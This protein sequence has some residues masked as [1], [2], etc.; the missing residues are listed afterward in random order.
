MLHI[1]ESQARPIDLE[2]LGDSNVYD[3]A[4]VA[5][6]Y[7]LPGGV[8]AA[9]TDARPGTEAQ[10]RDT[11]HDV[12]WSAGEARI[13]PRS[14]DLSASLDQLPAPDES[15][16]EDI[17]RLQARSVVPDEMQTVYASKRE[18]SDVPPR[19]T[20]TCELRAWQLAENSQSMDSRALEGVR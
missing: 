16:A 18:K 5:G 14:M 13:P 7:N 17:K 20:C 15:M 8:F 11:T 10:L 1:N 2:L 12:P 19:Y 6:L 4:E 9:G 3:I